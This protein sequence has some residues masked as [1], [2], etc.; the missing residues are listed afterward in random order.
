MSADESSAQGGGSE[1]TP[2]T[3][4]LEELMC[5][6]T[7][8]KDETDGT[9]CTQ[10]HTKPCVVVE[11]ASPMVPEAGRRRE[12]FGLFLAV[13]LTK[14]FGEDVGSRA[15]PPYAWTTDIITSYLRD[16]INTI[17]Q[18]KILNQTECIVFSGV[19]T[20]KEGLTEEQAYVAARRVAGPCGWV[21]HDV[22]VRAAPMTLGEASHTIANAKHF[23][24]HQTLHRIATERVAK[25]TRANAGKSPERPPQPRGR[26]MTR[27][28]DRYTAQKAASG[29]QGALPT[30]RDECI[31][32]NS[33][34]K[35][36]NKNNGSSGKGNKHAPD[37]CANNGGDDGSGDPDPFDE[38]DFSD[39]DDDDD[40]DEDDLTELSDSDLEAGES[41]GGYTT[42]QSRYSTIQSRQR[43]RNKAKRRDRRRFRK[44]K[45]RGGGG[46]PSNAPKHFNLAIFR[47][48]TGEMSISYQDWRKDVN[49]LLRRN[50][51]KN[52]IRDA[53]MHSVEGVPGQTAGVAYKKGEGSLDAILK[54]LD[55]V[56]G[57]SISYIKLNSD[58]CAIRQ[59]Y[60]EDVVTYYTR[61]NSIVH[62]L[63]EHHDHLFPPGQLDV[64]AKNA[65]YDG[66]LE[67]Y[68]PRISHLRDDPTK[69]VSD[70]LA[71][72]RK[73]EEQEE[74]YLSDRRKDSRNGY[75]K[76]GSAP[77]KGYR[78]YQRDTSN[79]NNNNNNN[80]TN[81]KD[82]YGVRVGNPDSEGESE[83]EETFTE[84][85]RDQVYRDGIYVGISR[86]ADDDD[87]R[88]GTCFNCKEMGHMWR[89]CPQ[90][91]RD[92][93]QR[94]KDR[95]GLDH[96]RLNR[97]G[98]GGAKGGRPSR[99]GIVVRTSETTPAPQ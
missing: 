99:K 72:V 95:E 54:A 9:R 89:Q 4:Q 43:K 28:Y 68:Q 65:F 14:P 64:F 69:D 60:E 84:E 42:E 97:S 83:E 3:S 82:G 67:K 37:R 46:G 75:Q 66:L 56:H 17:T 98:E 59:Y 51:P 76:N 22:V 44:R 39:D 86:M 92:D 29:L 25:A 52:K 88:T 38:G 1:E 45:D 79:H 50:I 57:Q 90:P 87:K 18:I 61:M 96:R 2:T 49:D 26:G 53:I 70:L 13:E 62:L 12:L 71:S 40:D 63:Q 21:G 23:I 8:I 6:I 34:D 10:S 55:T 7:P 93:L 81:R 94:A 30:L 35:G 58:L 91:L 47:G 31:T 73:T 36:S 11:L 78:S 80:N 5:T 27:R 16:I 19:R 15:V 85:D 74:R 33:K 48:T 41:D 24:R 77:T 32:S 20:R